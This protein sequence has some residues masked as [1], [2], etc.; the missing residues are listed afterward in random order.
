MSG[1][2]RSTASRK[3]SG[4]TAVSGGSCGSVLASECLAD[5]GAMN[6][7]MA[8]A[9]V[10]QTSARDP[11]RALSRD[12]MHVLMREERRDVT[13]DIRRESKG[14][15]RRRTMQLPFGV[16]P[17]CTGQ[18]SE[19]NQRPYLTSPRKQARLDIA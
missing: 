12:G 14:V 3:R 17:E 7:R 2:A 15:P 18:S 11:T 10:A 1:T 8:H 5:A 4:V 9:A 6:A 19:R 13:R 16:A